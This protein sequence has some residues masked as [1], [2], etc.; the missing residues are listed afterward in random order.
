[1]IITKVRRDYYRWPRAIPIRNGKNTWSDVQRCVLRLETEEGVTG[2]GI[3]GASPGEVAI[4]AV[5]SELLIG[6]D[7]DLI[8]Q[9]LLTLCDPK[10]YGRRGH[11][12]YAISTVDMALWDLKAKAARMPLHRLLGGQ[13][14][15]VPFYIAG[16]YYG[17]NKTLIDLQREVEGYLLLG[18][19]GV[20][21][22]VGGATI[23]EDVARVRAAREVL[24]NNFS[25]MLDAN[26]A[27]QPHEAI[28]F[29]K[30]V[31][32]FDIGWFEEPVGPEE[33]GGYERVCRGLNIP[34]AAGEQEYGLSGF[35]DLLATGVAIAQPDARW[36][37]GVTEF[38]RI[39][40]LAEAQGVSISSHGDQQIHAPLMAVTRRGLLA[41]YYA[42][43]VDPNSARFYQHPIATTP[44]G[45]LE[46]L[47][48]DGGGWDPNASAMEEF[49]VSS[50]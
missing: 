47:Q 6:M 28:A 49:L 11:E 48:V 29:G 15:R 20:K 21:I 30:R 14:E 10:V 34:I 40:V 1:M 26:C 36:T 3:G 35:R 18:A 4:L 45:F 38:L 5:Y 39:A 24:G 22:K 43:T 31:E 44:D 37:G 42:S 17:E 19:Q 46:L 27:Y 16:G 8:G 41:E 25:L 23:E 7:A 9:V 13:T 50:L 33:Y 2:V 32:E 12:H